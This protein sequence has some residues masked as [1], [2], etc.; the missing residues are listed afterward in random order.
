MQTVSI[1]WELSPK[2]KKENKTGVKKNGED[3]LT[4]L[5]CVSET[6]WKSLRQTILL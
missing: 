4:S 2:L 3:S 1:S 5:I 6:E